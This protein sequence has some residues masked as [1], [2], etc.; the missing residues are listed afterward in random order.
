MTLENISLEIYAYS[1]Q[2]QFNNWIY[3][4]INSAK[5]IKY[6]ILFFGGL[7]TGLNPCLI[8]IVPFS[9]AYNNSQIN[10]NINKTYL[11]LGISSSLPIIIILVS[12]LS[13]KYH[14]FLNKLPMII[15]FFTVIAGLFLLNIVPSNIG[16]NINQLNK[17]S[18][19]HTYI[20][21]YIIGFFLGLNITPCSSPALI[22]VLLPVYYSNKYINSAVYIIIYLIGYILPLILIVF[23]TLNKK[24]IKSIEQFWNII[25]PISGCLILWYGTFS[26]LKHIF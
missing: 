3:I 9:F 10:R 24:L 6:I 23:L 7:L 18:T 21:D 12:L 11:A 25:T 19:V 22:T 8:S 15:S 1:I 13:Y 16:S 17:L 2:N 20:K 4:Q 5:N 14:L 26:L